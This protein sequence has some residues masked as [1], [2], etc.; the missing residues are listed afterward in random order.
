MHKIKVD[1][2]Q[3]RPRTGFSFSIEHIFDDVRRRLADRIEAAV[4]ISPCYNDGFYTKFINTIQAALKQD[5]QVTH[6]TGEVH[7]LNL[8][9]RKRKTLLTIHDCGMM[10]RKT[11]LAKKIVQWLYLTGPVNKAAMVTTVSEAT[12]QQ[13][14]AYTGVNP[15]KVVVIPVA[16]NA[17]FQPSARAFNKQKPVILQIGTSY[18]KNLERVIA[19]LEGVPCHLSI[20]GQLAAAQLSLLEAYH[21]EYSNEYNITDER[22]LEKY[23]ECDFLVFASTAEGFGMPIIEANAVER[24]VITSNRSSMPEVAG[25]AACLVDPFDVDDIRRGILEVINNNAYREELISNGRINK[26]RFDGDVIADCYYNLYK[27]LNWNN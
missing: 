1:F 10:G 6:I 20:V 5:K 4:Y 27:R 3:R 9:M 13:V 15:D 18:N 12:K 21:I 24:P 16:V 19:A 26:L 22:L 2:F 7:F 23:Q 14:I 11:G 8:L 25:N 17:V